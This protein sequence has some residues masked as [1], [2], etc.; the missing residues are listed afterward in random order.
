MILVRWANG[1]TIEFR[2]LSD[3]RKFKGASWHGAHPDEAG[4]LSEKSLLQVFKRL[5]GSA[6][7]TAKRAADGFPRQMIGT[8]NYT[9]GYIDHAIVRP[10]LR[11]EP[12]PTYGQAR[13]ILS[14][15]YDL[16][17]KY[18]RIS[19]E[20]GQPT[21]MQRIINT[22]LATER[23]MREGWLAPEGTVWRAL[24]DIGPRRDIISKAEF[25]AD[26]G[27]PIRA[28]ERVYYAVD[29]GVGD[30][31]VIYRGVIRFVPGT[32]EKVLI[33]G[34][35]RCEPL[36]DRPHIIIANW[37]REAIAPAGNHYGWAEAKNKSGKHQSGDVVTTFLRQMQR[38]GLT[39]AR[40]IGN[41]PNE[42]LMSIQCVSGALWARRLVLIDEETQELQREWDGY[43]KAGKNAPAGVDPALPLKDCKDDHCCDTI[44]YL[45]NG[46]VSLGLIDVGK[47]MMTLLAEWAVDVERVA[48]V[49]EVVRRTKPTDEQVRIDQRRAGVAG[50][51]ADTFGPTATQFIRFQGH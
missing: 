37:L 40:A 6:D 33:V 49:E 47:E 34:G 1:S 21:Y 8:L 18:N 26:W 31:T 19:Q 13:F 7:S 24:T 48:K 14:T 2:S 32:A 29:H 41:G 11:K 3:P 25:L 5:S 22:G 17:K 51:M 35:E 20:T 42:K 30:P 4:D 36:K 46:V 43:M 50:A 15:P 23:E 16:E 44:R 45:V 12:N 27:G 39:C 10:A 38:A 9:K 28:D